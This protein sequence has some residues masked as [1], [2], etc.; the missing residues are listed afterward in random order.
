MPGKRMMGKI[1]T[2]TGTAKILKGMAFE[3]QERT[4]SFGML[5][6]PAIHKYS[7]EICPS[8][9]FLIDTNSQS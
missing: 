8:S 2:L 1:L 4:Y 5:T 6:T 9:I 3:T 7:L